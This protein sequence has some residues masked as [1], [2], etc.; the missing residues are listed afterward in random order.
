MK[1]HPLDAMMRVAAIAAKAAEIGP[2]VPVVATGTPVDDAIATLASEMNRQS[3]KM[4]ADNARS[5]KTVEAIILDGVA[6]ESSDT[7]E[8]S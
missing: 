1:S 5:A 7:K 3:A 8:E 6:P 2:A 4:A